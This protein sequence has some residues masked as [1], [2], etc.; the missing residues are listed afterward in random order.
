MWDFVCLIKTLYSRLTTT[1]APWFP[2]KDPDSLRLLYDILINEEVDQHPIPGRVRYCSH[3]EYYYAAMEACGADTDPITHCLAAL[4]SS[5]SLRTALEHP[6]VLPCTR[7]F[8]QH[9]FAVFNRSTPVLAAYFVFGREAMIADFFTPWLAQLKKHCVPQYELLAYYL[10]R[11]INLDGDDHFP[12]AAQLLAN[13]CGDDQRRW[14][15]VT[16]AARMALRQRVYFLNGVY[17]ALVSSG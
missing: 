9:T 4:R 11:H 17:D 7:D 12:R 16:Q 2:A 8:V 5:A 6:K 3:F 1:T 15:Q 13:L 10:A 14:T